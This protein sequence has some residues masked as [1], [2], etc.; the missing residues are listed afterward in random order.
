M[1]INARAS[2]SAYQVERMLLD[3]RRGLPIVLVDRGVPVAVLPLEHF[4]EAKCRSWMDGDGN[5]PALVLTRHRLLQAGFLKAPPV[6]RLVPLNGAAFD[7]ARLQ[8][9]A[10]GA[11]VPDDGYFGALVPA[12]TADQAAIALARRARLIPAVLTVR[13]GARSAAEAYEVVRSGELL[14]ADAGAALRH[15]D[16]TVAEVRR[17]STARV[18]LAEAEDARF[19]VFRESF[20]LR[21]HVAVLI[22]EQQDWLSPPPVRVHSSC[23]TGDLFASLR[24]DC[25]EQLRAGVARIEALGGGVLLYLSQ[26]G[27]NIGLANKLRAY[28]L[29][30]AGR[31]TVDADAQLGFADDER[32]YRVAIAML[33]ALGLTSV[34]LLTN[35]PA[36]VAAMRNGG[37]EV[38]RE[39]LYG[40]V[41]EE[42]RR[43]LDAKTTRSG[44]LLREFLDR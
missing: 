9:Q 11:S 6:G 18:P 41:T 7:L 29:Q 24:C 4:D 33:S 10:F 21:E 8:A 3:L 34:R 32:D 37:I 42:N 2:T 12:D 19:V 5:R 43:Y 14:A 1:D 16:G 27:R 13:L 28:T 22:G 15:A 30:D 26:E 36:K 39:A 17:I 38:D 40:R 20:G 25:G 31:D 23:L 35:N 44:H